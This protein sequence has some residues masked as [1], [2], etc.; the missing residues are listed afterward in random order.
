MVRMA[1]TELDEITP[2]TLINQLDTVFYNDMDFAAY[3]WNDINFTEPFYWD[4]TSN[5]IIDFSYTDPDVLE[6][7]LFFGEDPGFNCGI[8]SGSNNYALDLDGKTDFL[9][10][11][12]D[13]YFNSDFTFEAWIYKRNNN[14]W[15]R[16]FDFGNGPNKNNV[17]VVLSNSGSGKF[18]FHIN[19]DA[20]KPHLY[21]R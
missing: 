12:E 20:S 3:N 9:K 16:V 15:S 2:D 21:F 4:G 6:S 8:S 13:T 10:L 19:N 11:P 14:T 7:T 5:I 18:S 17:I 1:S